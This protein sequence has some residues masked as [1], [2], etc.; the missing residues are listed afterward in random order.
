MK[1]FRAALAVMLV[2]LTVL[3]VPAAAQG[4]GKSYVYNHNAEVME[5]PDPYSIKETIGYDFGF[6]SPVDMQILDDVLFV[7]DA[8]RTAKTEDIDMLRAA[9]IAAYEAAAGKDA[10][11]PEADA[12]AAE[13]P[14]ADAEAPVADNAEGADVPVVADE[15]DA[16]VPAADG[17]EAATEEAPADGKDETKE[18]IPTKIPAGTFRVGVQVAVFDKDYNIMSSLGEGVD[19]QDGTITFTDK[20]GDDYYFI[21]PRGLWVEKTGNDADPYRLYIA[22]RGRNALLIF[23]SNGQLL[24]KWGLPKKA[25]GSVEPM[26][27]HLTETSYLPIRVL[28]DHL[29]YVYLRVENEYRGFIKLAPYEEGKENAEFYGYFGQNTV[30]RTAD[31]IMLRFFSNF[32]TEAQKQNLQQL[33]PMGYSNFCIDKNDFIYGVRGTTEDMMELIRKLNCK[34]KN[35]LDYKETFGDQGLMKVGNDAKTTSFNAITVDDKGFITAFDS[36]WQRMFQY[37]AEGQ[38]MYVFGGKGTQEGTFTDGVDIEAWGDD[39]LVL[40]NKFRTITVMEPTTFGANVRGGEYAY[41]QGDYNESKGYFTKVAEECMNYEFAYA[42]IGKALYMNGQYKEAMDNFKLAHDQ[43]NY[44]MAFKMYR[45]EILRSL[46]VPMLIV[47][48]VLVLLLVVRA[49]LK[50]K[51]IIKEKKLILDESGKGKYVLHTILHPIE[52]FE[53]MRYNKKYSLGIANVAV[54]FFFFSTVIM[55]LYSG[56]IFNGTSAQTYNMLF[57]LVGM[58][59]GFTLFVLVNWLMS[60]FFEGKGT[61]KNVWIYLGYATIPYSVTSFLYT[62]LS[63]VLTAEEATF[64]G[65]LEIIGVGWAVVMA[66]FALQGV[67][68]YTFKRNI[69]SIFVTILGM[70]VVIFIVF[71][72]F[73]LFIQFFSFVESIFTEVMY[74]SVVGFN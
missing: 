28:T 39:L 36:T 4:T 31:A 60:T 66:L 45:G 10:E 54:F 29:G 38:L 30:T 63:N 7:L 14:E 34:S 12:P 11:L 37:N 21:D 6:A 8:G 47:V 50:K 40:D 65:Y 61:F 15:V 23:D 56:F 25:D 1:K 73:N 68:M 67:H 13:A 2:L 44:S 27:A 48:A 32:M 3:S 55:S 51:G 41:S 53:E 9:E 70:M 35:V 17:E 52:G 22:E 72:M 42:G 18:D 20:D 43:D 57:T 49:I 5:I 46:T 16:S 33:V 74:R 64:L 62:I 59:G 69:V 26:L 19:V 71:L 24:V 58:L